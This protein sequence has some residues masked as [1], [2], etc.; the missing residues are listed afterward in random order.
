MLCEQS[1]AIDGFY[2]N[3]EDVRKGALE[4]VFRSKYL[5]ITTKELYK[6]ALHYL[7]TSQNIIGMMGEVSQAQNIL[8]G[9]PKGKVLL[10]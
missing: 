10:G 8:G 2:I 5:E 1:H 3:I 7:Y 4:T 6:E 9:N